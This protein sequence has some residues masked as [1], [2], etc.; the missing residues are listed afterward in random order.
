M[1]CHLSDFQI[2][3]HLLLTSATAVNQIVMDAALL[4]IEKLQIM[5]C[6][7]VV[8]AG[9]WLNFWAVALILIV[10]ANV[11]NFRLCMI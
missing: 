8:M 6:F 5:T 4:A 10:C 3:S 2:C 7:V 9:L 1:I 11:E